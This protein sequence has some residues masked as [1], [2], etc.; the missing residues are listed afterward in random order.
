MKPLYV[1]AVLATTVLV[2]CGGGGGGDDDGGSPATPAIETISVSLTGDQEAPTPVLTAANAS[3]TVKINR[4]ARTLSATVTIDGL[5]PTV[6]HIHAGEAGQAGAIVFPM[7][8][9]GSV[10]T[11]VETPLT[12][13][14]LASLDA[15]KLYVNVH[16]AAHPA[17]E[18]RGQIGREVF[19]AELSGAQET[20]PVQTKARAAG[21][22]VLNPSDGSLSGEVEVQDV[23]ATAAHVHGAPFGSDG[24][25]V[26]PMHD[27]G[28][29]GHFTVPDNT[30]LSTEQIKAL[31][32]GEM[33]FNV[34]SAAHPG[35][36]IRGQIGRRI[37][38]AAANGAQEVPANA[39]T[40][41]G[42][43]FVVY[44]AVTRKMSGK[45]A[46]QGLNATVAHIH[47]A[48]AGSNGPVVQE[49]AAPAAGSN[50]WLIPASAPALTVERARALLNGEFYYNAHSAAFPAG[51]IRGQLAQP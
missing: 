18:L 27:H 3:G 17:G 45:L 19:T 10:A 22:L 38:L 9:E 41:T 13:E 12:A 30:K 42:T 48:A 47:A 51:E 15:G 50:D 1:F 5:T 35:G 26:I 6:A 4:T 21:L 28:G 32:A 39:S 33:Y 16:S 44:D 25:I 24:P 43:G 2:A 11:L 46:L 20:R 34:H 36:E 49:L 8:L 31:R 37:L 14:Q 7:T 29:H 23:V 40:A